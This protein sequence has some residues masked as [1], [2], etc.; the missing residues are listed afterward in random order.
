MKCIFCIK[1]EATNEILRRTTHILPLLD[2][3]LE[4]GGRVYN[5]SPAAHFN[6][7]VE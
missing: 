4:V 7:E 6:G 3:P 1:A 2:G 5:L